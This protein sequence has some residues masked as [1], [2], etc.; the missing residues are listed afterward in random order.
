VKIKG[1]LL[2]LDDTLYLYEPNHQRAQ[3]AVFAFVIKKYHL[4]E[5]TVNRSF[6]DA[7]HRLKLMLPVVAANH[8]RILYFQLMFEAL[9]INPLPNALHASDLYWNTFVDNMELTE[10]ANE[11]LERNCELPIC[12]LTDL[13]SEIQYKKIEKLGLQNY[14]S[15]I[16]T[17]E[18]SGFE[19]PH[20]FMF[21]LGLSKLK[22]NANEVIMIGDNFSKDV[23]GASNLGI[24]S[25]WINRNPML[26]KDMPSNSQTILSLKEVPL[27]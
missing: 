11:F 1:I 10:D 14:I 8:S 18:E 6:V 24:Q 15:Q 16:V 4:D 26:Q 27:L 20:P 7:K 23:L 12:L 9:G 3:E 17:S 21:M 19:K 2:D 22:L 5:K 13:T 25:Y